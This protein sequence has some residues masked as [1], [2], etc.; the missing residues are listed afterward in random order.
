MRRFLKSFV[1]AMTGIRA[2]T[3]SE[4]SLKLHLIATV[5]AIIIGIYVNLSLAEWGIVALTVGFVLAA[6]L[7]NTAIERLG[8]EAAGGQ[9]KLVVKH[10]KDAAAGAVL[11]SAAAALVVGI[12]FLI[13]P[14]FEKLTG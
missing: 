4:L 8:D 7:F 6:E 10:A 11:V 9:F 13:V 5:I 14:L 1:F 12:I 2:A 3:R